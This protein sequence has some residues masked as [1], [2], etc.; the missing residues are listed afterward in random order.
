ML[1]LLAL[2]VLK[3]LVTALCLGS[4]A[5]GGLLTPTPATGAALGGFLGI[6]WSHL[7]PGTPVGVYA[8][9][10]AAALLGAGMQAPPTALVLVLELTH[11]GFAIMVPLVIATSLATAVARRV[12]G[13]SI[14]SGRLA[15]RPGAAGPRAR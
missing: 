2:L 7:W 4:G 3:P 5:S 8:L 1:L 11:S 10:G 13:Y 9:L 15:A 14:Y 12:D 6:A